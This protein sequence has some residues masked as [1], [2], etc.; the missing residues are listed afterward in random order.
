MHFLPLKS[1]FEVTRGHQPSFAITFDQKEVEPWDWCQYVRLGQANRLICN[2]TQFGLHVTLARLDLRSNFDLELS[3][4]FYTWFDVPE[5][6]EHDI[7]K[8]VALP[9][10]LKILSSKNRFGKFRIGDLNF[11]LNQKMTEMISK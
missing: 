9:L 8:M 5:R 6:D 4:S 3:G 7:I 11:N 10:K 2:M 1:S